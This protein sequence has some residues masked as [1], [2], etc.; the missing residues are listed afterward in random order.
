MHFIY[1]FNTNGALQ[2]PMDYLNYLMS[3]VYLLSIR[4]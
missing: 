3:I 1:G 4:I 2:N